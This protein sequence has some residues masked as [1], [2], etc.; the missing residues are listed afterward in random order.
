MDARKVIVIKDESED[1]A[2][3]AARAGKRA[4]GARAKPII[5]AYIAFDRAWGKRLKAPAEK[6]PRL[7][8]DG[9]PPFM[10]RPAPAPAPAEPEEAAAAPAEAFSPPHTP[11]LPVEEEEG[12]QGPSTVLPLFTSALSTTLTAAEEAAETRARLEEHIAHAEADQEEL[13]VALS[14]V[15]RNS[16][17]EQW[18]DE[19]Q[20]RNNRKLELLYEAQ[21]VLDRAFAH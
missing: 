21:S 9:L 5:D 8:P 17:Q 20:W 11:P 2:P 7:R 15:P 19:A 3:I 1:E 18:L 12:A 14:V 6:R 4:A 16:L 10:H 13:A